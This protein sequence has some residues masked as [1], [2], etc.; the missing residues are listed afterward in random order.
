M[1]IAILA[2]AA[3]LAAA[4]AHPAHAWRQGAGYLVLQAPLER[5]ADGY[6]LDLAGSGDWVDLTVPLAAHNCKGP[7]FFPDQAVVLEGGRIRFPAYGACLTAL[8]R[9]GRSLPG[10]PLLAR[11]CVAEGE[12]PRG[13]FEM[14]SLQRFRQRP[15]G[16]I[17]LNGG[18]LCLTVGD[19][20]DTTF[21]PHD[22]W[23]ALYLDECDEAPAERS[24]WKPFT[25]RGG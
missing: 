2:A 11:A 18:G 7:Q 14:A 21:S 25:P 9:D 6:C 3:L 10:M 5:A 15:D 23:R 4:T 24:A 22:H 13:P 17:E 12:A 8:G 16:R 1:R 20:W 19:R